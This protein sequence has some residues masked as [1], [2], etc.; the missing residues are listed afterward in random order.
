M[1]TR[2]TMLGQVGAAASAAWAMRAGVAVGAG[3]RTAVD[4]DIPRGA[5]DCHV[6]V[7]GDPAT[8][9]F[10]EKR[11]YTPPQASIEQLLEL[12]RDLRLERVVVVQPS[13]YGADNACTVDAVRR[14][15]RACP[16]GRGH[17]QDHLAQDAGGDGGGR[18]SRRAA[19]PRDQYRGQ[20]RS[21]RRQG[22]ARCHRRA[23]P[24]PGLA[25]AG[26]HPHLRSSPP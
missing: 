19:Q 22:P 9:P 11:I 12:Q 2:R 1:L 10:A 15:R 14:M 7:F 5:C 3:G 20:V 6:H 25:R 17:R 24:R 21:G 16:R 4:F 23:D 13:V 26:L 18:N 8:F